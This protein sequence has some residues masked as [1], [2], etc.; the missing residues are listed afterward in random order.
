[1]ITRSTRRSL[2]IGLLAAGMA[3]GLAGCITLLP[4]VKPVQ[5]YTIRFNPALLQKGEVKA[6]PA[7]PD[8]KPIDVFVNFD[9]FPRAA[10][11]DRILTTE[12]NEVSYVSGGRWASSAQGQFRDLMSEGFAREASQDVRLGDQ[13]RVS[14][15]YRLDIN[16]RRFEAA[17]AKRRP[18]VVVALDARLVR[19]KDRQVMAET[20]ISSEVAVRKSDL[21]PMVEG[22]ETAA[23]RVTVDVIA[24]TETAVA[25][26]RAKEAAT[27]TPAQ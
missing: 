24:F 15:E 4:E 8:A 7:T 3:T 13:G 25:D 12:G 1:M 16:V 17:Y 18:T 2:G 10:A 11:G 9:G 27:A 14:G 19:L 22:F 6:P 23:S 20:F 5:L 21:T 26:A